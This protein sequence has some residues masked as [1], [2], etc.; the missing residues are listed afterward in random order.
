MQ[1]GIHDIYTVETEKGEVLVPAVSEFVK[2][3][4]LEKGIFIKAIEG[5]FDEV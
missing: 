1:Y 2:E 3:I 5:M 4:S